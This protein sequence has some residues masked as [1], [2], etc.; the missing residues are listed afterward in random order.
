MHFPTLE[1]RTAIVTGAAGSLGIATVLELRDCGCRV[2]ALD[3]DKPGL[4]KLAGETGIHTAVC[5]LLDARDAERALGDTWQKYGPI[6]ILVNTVGLIYSSPLINIAARTN[7]R[8]S[9]E[10]WRRVIDINL[11]AVFVVTANIVDQM[12]SSRTRGVVVNFSSVSAAGNAGQAAYAAAKAGVIA[13]TNSWARELGP[14]GI[15][16]VTIAPGF[17]DTPSTR[18]ALPDPTIQEWTRR[19]P[20]KRMGSVDDVVSAVIFAVTNEHLTGKVVEIDGGLTI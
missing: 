12:V 13:M 5:D 7:R 17:I 6:S 10:A 8:H 15:R 9:L 4:D 14:L 11:T 19:I 1:N 18:A 20:L 2:V 3:R 16:F